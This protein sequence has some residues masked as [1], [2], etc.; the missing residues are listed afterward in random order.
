MH[1]WL[2]VKSKE[3]LWSFS[4]FYHVA[5]Q[6]NVCLKISM[7]EVTVLEFTSSHKVWKRSSL[8]MTVI[9][10][11]QPKRCSMYSQKWDVGPLPP[12]EALS[13]PSSPCAQ[14]RGT[15]SLFSKQAPLTGAFS[16]PHGPSALCS[17]SPSLCPKQETYPILQDFSVAGVTPKAGCSPAPGVTQHG[18][19][20]WPALPHVPTAIP[21]P[22]IVSHTFLSLWLKWQ[23]LSPKKW[24]WHCIY[25]DFC[26]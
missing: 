16:P 23:N 19:P 3:V 1:I 5:S 14:P 12:S 26:M 10:K 17:S 18:S 11:H 24:L 2:A 15:C 21:G 9:P 4:D 22:F 6:V 7:W 20:L 8:C 25:V 13:C